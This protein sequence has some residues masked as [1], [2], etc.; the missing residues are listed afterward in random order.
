MSLQPISSY[1]KY[2]DRY[3]LLS[4]KSY[5]C[6]FFV[7]Y[8]KKYIYIYI[9]LLLW[10]EITVGYLCYVFEHINYPIIYTF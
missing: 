5:V 7:F 3:I 2:M 9:W 1:V 6:N 8:V 10:T 4:I